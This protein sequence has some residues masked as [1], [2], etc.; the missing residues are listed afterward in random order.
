MPGPPGRVGRLLP[1][2]P[3]LAPPGAPGRELGL[4][5]VLGERAGD[6]LHGAQAFPRRFD[7]LRCARRVA[8]RGGQQRRAHRHRQLESRVDELRGVLLVPVAARVRQRTEQPLGLG[9]LRAR[10]AVLLLARRARE[11][12][13]PPREDLVRR[14]GLPFRDRAQQ[15]AHAAHPVLLPGRRLRDERDQIVEVGALDRHG[16]A[17]RQRHDPQPPVRV[18][19]GARREELLERPL[20]GAASRQLLDERGA[21]V[22]ANLAAGD[23]RPVA[24]LL[25]VQILR[26]DA[27]PFARDHG[28]PSSHVRRHGDEPRRRR[29]LPS[30]AALHAPARCRRDARAFAVEVRVEE[31]VQRDDP[32]VVCCRLGNEVDDDAGL[33]ARMRAHDPPD[34][35]LVDAP[36][37]GR[38]KVHAHGRTRRVPAFR[39][40]HRVDE[41]VDLAAFVRRQ[42][43]GELDGRSPAGHGLRREPRRAELLREVVRVLD[44]S[45]ID[46]A[47]CVVEAVAV[48]ARGRLVQRLVVEGLGKDLLVEVAADDRDLVDRRHRRD[49]QA[50]QRRDQPASRSVLQRQVV[51]GGREDVGHLLGDQLLGRRHADVD[52]L[53]ERA[54]RARRLLSERGVRLV[55]DHELIRVPRERGLVAREP[56]VRLDRERVAA[57]QRLR[58]ALD[59]RREAVAV[60][61]GGQVALELRDEQAAVREDEHAERASGFDEAG[62]GDRLARSGRMAEAITPHRARIGPAEAVLFLVVLVED[63]LGRVLLGLRL[64]LDRLDDGAVAVRLLLVRRDQLGE[65]PRQRVDLVAAELGAGGEVR[66]RLG[67]HA[68]EPEHEAVLDFPAGRRLAPARLD[69]GKGVVERAPA[70]RSGRERDGRVFALPEEG[71]P[72]PGFGSEGGGR[73]TVRCLRRCRRLLFD[74]LHERSAYTGAALS[75][76][77]D[78]ANPQG[79]G[80][81]KQYIG[82]PPEASEY[83]KW[84][85]GGDLV[86]QLAARL[87]V[88]VDALG[89]LD[90]L[91]A[92]GRAR[93]DER[94]RPRDVEALGPEL[95]GE[96]V[97]LAEALA[98][99]ADLPGRVA[100]AQEIL[101]DVAR[102]GLV[103]PALL[104]VQPAFRD[105][106]LRRQALFLQLL[107]DDAAR[108]LGLHARRRVDEDGVAVARHRKPLLAQLVG[109]LL[110]VAFRHAEPVQEAAGAL[111]VG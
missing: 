84:V 93:D 95:V 51:D 98:L 91:L 9:E 2:L 11:A 66:P 33:L 88:A 40:Q 67:E 111:L 102:V 90:G 56:R 15:D 6:F 74:L 106:A 65:H 4:R 59:R 72:G 103:V 13:R 7:Q 12:P 82:L 80:R 32:L 24:L 69:L 18:L 62:R 81:V 42:R 1:P 35:L 105:E 83:R 48:E 16:D 86:D 17:V 36:R 78:P 79:A 25:L 54:D 68:L 64:V 110:G 39:E 94:E 50:A 10:T 61:L 55:A 49:A 99:D 23:R 41:D 29:Q 108:L 57:A 44:A 34:A 3:P 38:R 60:P 73:Q 58:A 97:G 47:G 107:L 27:L 46:D 8:L 87:H 26:I 21:L 96:L 37:S 92:I 89:E 14:V 19:R 31:R 85:G 53:G 76:K 5:E 43:L 30:R 20:G 109:E 45:R 100:A 52:G 101:L 75:E 104:V 28:K 77:G 71:L 70:G 63:V 22:E